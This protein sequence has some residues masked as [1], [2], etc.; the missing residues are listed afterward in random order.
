MAIKVNTDPKTLIIAAL[1]IGGGYLLTNR[2]KGAI[3]RNVPMGSTLV[4]AGSAIVWTRFIV[5]AVFLLF[6]FFILHRL[7]AAGKARKREKRRQPRLPNQPGPGQYY[8]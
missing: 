1:L 6:V 7:D 4:K 8:G 5:S 2:A 3:R